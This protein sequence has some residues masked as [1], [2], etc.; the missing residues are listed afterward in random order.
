MTPSSPRQSPAKSDIY[1]DDLLIG[2]SDVKKIETIYGELKPQ[3]DSISHG[4]MI[5]R[6]MLRTQTETPERLI[7]AVENYAAFQNSKPDFDPQYVKSMRNFFG[8][9]TYKIY[10]DS[11]YVR[12]APKRPNGASVEL[13]DKATAMVGRF[14]AQEAPKQDDWAVV[15]DALRKAS[16]SAGELGR[17]NE[18][19]IGRLKK[20]YLEAHSG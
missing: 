18:Y 3:D 4:C 5:V 11:A 1:D 20:Q 14:G 8:D 17:A 6:R 13:F 15:K 16:I 2:D 9:Q 7:R 12:P 19:E 10:A